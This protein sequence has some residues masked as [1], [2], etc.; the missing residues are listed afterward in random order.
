MS[1]S[2]Y[3]GT[4]SSGA[5]TGSM[6][7][8]KIPKGYSQGRLQNFTPEQ[9]QLFQSLFGHLGPN[10][11]TSR[12]A[13]GDQSA[14]GE[15]EKPALQQ[16]AGLQGQTASR[17][18]G[19]GSGARKSSGFQNEM[20]QGASQFADQLASQRQGLQRQALQDLMGMSNTLL[21][22]RPYENFLQKKSPSFW[23]S[24]GGEAA[25]G[26]GDY[27]GGGS[28]GGGSIFAQLFGGG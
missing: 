21:G 15:I 5:A 10:S 6:L 26:I 13:G 17:F 3:G 12:L 19:M 9:F 8:N 22:Q 20:T 2:L 23:Q 16:F 11:F 27:I 24:L 25:R 4:G 18:S 14:F 7:G 1:S 28:K